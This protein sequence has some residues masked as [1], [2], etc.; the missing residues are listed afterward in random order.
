MISQTET[1]RRLAAEYDRKRVFASKRRNMVRESMDD[2]SFL[3]GPVTN[4]PIDI[5]GQNKQKLRALTFQAGRKSTP[6]VQ[7]TRLKSTTSLCYLIWNCD[8]MVSRSARTSQILWSH[9]GL[10]QHSF[11]TLDKWLRAT[12]P[13]YHRWKSENMSWVESRCVKLCWIRLHQSTSPLSSL[14]SLSSS[15]LPEVQ[16][17]RASNSTET[18]AKSPVE[19]G[20][21]VDES[22]Q[23]SASNR[24]TFMTRGEVCKI[25]CVEGEQG[26]VLQ[27]V[28]S[29]ASFRGAAASDQQVFTVLSLHI[30]NISVKEKGIAK[31][32][33]QT[34][35]AIM[36]SQDVDL[37]A[38]DFNGTAWRCC[39]RDNLSTID[40]VFSDCAL[41]K[42]LGPPP[43]W[44]PGSIP[45]NWAD[46]CGFLMLPGFQRF[47]IV[48]KHG[49][50]KLPPSIGI[51][52]GTIKLTT[53]GTFS[54]S[55]DQRVL[56]MELK[57]VTSARF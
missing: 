1:Q 45:N 43:L 46:V 52:N 24:S 21:L 31:K 57:N 55:N 48:N 20:P 16:N 47:W 5:S 4:K 19:L 3:R 34:I 37:V 27:G 53:T 40:E 32:I 9:P 51:P 17:R 39:S 35:R 15:H 25:I 6:T 7:W 12:E 36:I 22:E 23:E 33:I 11:G 28:L 2:I 41:P 49:A 10:L 18:M 13:H 42:P 56:D 30:S 38:G 54:S 14:P 26:W 8:H 29:R 50:S 44:G